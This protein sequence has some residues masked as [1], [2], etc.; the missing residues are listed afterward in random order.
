LIGLGGAVG[1]VLRYLLSGLVHSGTDASAFPVGTLAVN[2]IGCFAIGVLA[3]LSEA[4]GFL[5]ADSRAMIVAGVIG[6]FTTFS[7]FANETVSAVRDN[8]LLIAAGNILL[9]VGLGLLAVLAGRALAHAVW[10]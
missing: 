2:L 7:T 8:A 1:S 9:S 4:R 3:E 5:D 6:G 10:G